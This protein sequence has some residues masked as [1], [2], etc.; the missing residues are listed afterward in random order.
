MT[1][2][3]FSWDAA[4]AMEALAAGET[5]LWRWSPAEDRLSLHG[6]T[7]SL[8]LQVIGAGCSAVALA[9]VA[10][11]ADRAEVEALLARREPGAGVRARLRL[12]S[13]QALVFAGAWADEGPAH[14]TGT[15][16][17][18]TPAAAVVERDGLTGLLDRRSFLARARERLLQPGRYVL[19]V[20]DLDRLRRLNEALGHDRADLLLGALGAR[21]A[22]ARTST[23][24]SSSPMR[25]G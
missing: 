13:G 5:V 8:G 24:N 4:A 15:A 3:R 11:P 21:L 1:A 25:A 7:R 19:V 17:R 6:A 20:A 12:R 9:A 10:E 14:A 22:A 23:A 18:E 2:E 16:A